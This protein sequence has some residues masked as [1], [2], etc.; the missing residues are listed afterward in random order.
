MSDSGEING[1]RPN[2]KDSNDVNSDLVTE[3]LAVII[4]IE[5]NR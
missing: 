1:E 3:V 2:V 5:D 4:N